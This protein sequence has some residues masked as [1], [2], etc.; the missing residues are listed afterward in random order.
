LLL[1]G[2]ELASVGTERREQTNSP[3]QRSCVQSESRSQHLTEKHK[4]CTHQQPWRRRPQGGRICSCSTRNRWGRR[5]IDRG[6]HWEVR[7][8][9][10]EAGGGTEG[11]D[12]AGDLTGRRGPCLLLWA[13]C[14]DSSHGDHPGGKANSM[15]SLA[16]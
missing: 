10:G 14:V 4:V 9:L 1:R 12:F 7:D 15:A 2:I 6:A 5:G 8:M 13:D 16:C 3:A 11:P